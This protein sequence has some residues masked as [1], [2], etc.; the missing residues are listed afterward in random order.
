MMLVVNLDRILVFLST[1]KMTKIK[2]IVFL[3]C[4]I[5]FINWSVAV[6]LY[7][8]RLTADPVKFLLHDS[9][10][11]TLRFLLITLAMTPLKSITSY[12]GFIKVRRMLGLWTFFYGS[13]HLLIYTWLDLDLNFTHLLEDIIKRPYI[14]V[15]FAAWLLMVP[16]AVTSNQKMIRKLGLKWK[17]LHKSIYLIA[18]LACLHFIWLVK[19][20][21]TEPLIYIGITVLLLLFRWIKHIRK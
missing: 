16:L 18:G 13:L 9:G 15:G 4:F 11:W 8:D 20:D 12:V 14:T 5:P 6:F 1:V 21:V 7:P 10:L 17:K 2:S 19:K 3:L